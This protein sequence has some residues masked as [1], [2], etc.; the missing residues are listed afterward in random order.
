[1]RSIPPLPVWLFALVAALLSPTTEATLVCGTW[2]GNWNQAALMNL[3]GTC[4][5][6]NCGAEC[7]YHDAGHHNLVTLSTSVSTLSA[8]EALC[9]QQYPN[10]AGCCYRKD[11]E[12]KY[13]AGYGIERANAG[14]RSAVHCQVLSPPPPPTCAAGQYVF[15]FLGFR[16]GSTCESCTPGHYQ[17]SAGYTGTSCHSCAQGQYQQSWGQSSCSSCAAGKYGRTSGATG[18][19]DCS[20]C[21]GGQYSSSS[22]R[23]SCTSCAA[24]QYQNN[25]G[26]TSCSSC[27][28]GQYQDSQGATGCKDCAS[29]RYSS[30]YGESSCM[31]CPSGQTSDPGDSSCTAAPLECSPGTYESSGTCRSC[32]TGRYQNSAGRTSCTRCAGGQYQGNTGQTSCISCAS[33]QYLRS[34]AGT[35]CIN[36]AAGQYQNGDGQTSC[37]FCGSGQYVAGAGQSGCTNCQSGKYQPLSNLQYCRAVLYQNRNLG[38]LSVEVTACNQWFTLDASWKN[39]VSAVVVEGED[40]EM[41]VADG[42]DG[43]QAY[44]GA[45]QVYTTG[46]YAN[47]GNLL[48]PYDTINSIY[49]S[50]P[51]EYV[52]TR[53]SCRDCASGQFQGSEGQTACATCLAYAVWPNTGSWVSATGS[54]S[55]TLECDPGHRA[56]G[57]VCYTC[58]AGRCV[59]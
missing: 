13:K 32:Q 53:T 59:A 55:C 11:T 20:N 45:N 57:E 22:G 16:G 38:G 12:C 19:S 35:S 5:D 21:N 40:C 51:A 49:L 46:I 15:E 50:C 54:S 23:T 2:H 24:G 29:G 52:P 31:Y 28:P 10:T 27:T 17:G 41:T 1:M 7:R 48:T 56:E 4:N 47:H 30:S 42:D 36:C 58:A 8:C 18:E 39:V 44:D 34:V 14:G 9:E 6:G 26:Q 25:F 43:N 3:D 37:K 33:G